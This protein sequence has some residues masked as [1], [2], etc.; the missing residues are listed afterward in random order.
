MMVMSKTLVTWYFNKTLPTSERDIADVMEAIE[1]IG[2]IRGVEREI[3]YPL[4]NVYT[5]TRIPLLLQ[6][7]SDY[8]V[9]HPSTEFNCFF[10]VYDGWREHTPPPTYTSSYSYVFLSKEEL[11]AEYVGVG[12]EG[13]PGR[14]ISQ[15]I[16]KNVNIFPVF[17]YPVMAFSRHKNDPS[18]ILVPDTD[19]I[20]SRGHVELKDEIDTYDIPWEEKKNAMVWRGGNNGM[21]YG[22]YNID[23]PQEV[24]V[25]IDGITTITTRLLNQRELLVLFSRRS[26]YAHMMNIQFSRKGLS[27]SLNKQS[28]LQY[29]YQ[30]D[31]DGEVNAWSGLIWKLYSGSVV[32]KVNSH[33]EQW[34][35]SNLH[36]WIH[37][38]PVRG[39]LQD[40]DDQIAWAMANDGVAQQIAQNGR[41]FVQ[42]LTYD[43]VVKHLHLTT[44]T[45]LSMVDV[46]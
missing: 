33:Y 20:A 10:T 24:S 38:I 35:Y 25:D 22:A 44:R 2:F 6:F 19:F 16:E 27:N 5:D 28:M 23:G 29:K 3:I 37:Y 8:L 43:G 39:D 4:F 7:L 31:I 1:E 15:N 26:K 11:I 42:N 40:L 18:V 32:F 12:V 46:Q 14:F 36:P 30:L 34:Y 41:A 9:E 45:L 21:G 17:Q 13:E